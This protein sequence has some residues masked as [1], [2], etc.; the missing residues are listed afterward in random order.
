TLNVTVTPDAIPPTIT[1]P[2]NITQATV[3]NQCSAVVSFSP[4]INDNCSGATFVCNPASGSTFLKG[5]TTVSCTA[6]DAANNTASCSFTVT[7]NDMQAPTVSC[8]AN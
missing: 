2:A 5:L 8:P 6:T 4:T 3:A 7:V 1:C